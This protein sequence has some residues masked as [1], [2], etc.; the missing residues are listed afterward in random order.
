[1]TIEIRPDDFVLFSKYSNPFNPITKIDYGLPKASNV[2][3]IIYDILGNEVT[4]RVNG[5]QGP[6]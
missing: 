4:T 5:V 6:G 2:Q 3:L 1:M